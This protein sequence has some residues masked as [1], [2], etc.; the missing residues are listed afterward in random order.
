VKLGT[1]VGRDK[2]NMII[3]PTTTDG[4][5]TPI[6]VIISDDKGNTKAAI[7]T[8]IAMLADHAVVWPANITDEQKATAIKQFDVRRLYFCVTYSS[9]NK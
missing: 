4:T 1:V 3:N 5:Q 2:D 9:N 6:G 8:R 7:V